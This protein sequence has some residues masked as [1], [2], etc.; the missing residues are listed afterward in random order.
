MMDSPGVHAKAQGASIV[1]VETL[2]KGGALIL[3]ASAFVSALAL[4]L[5]IF[6]LIIAKDAEREGRLAQYETT[7]LRGS[8]NAAGLSTEDP[9]TH[10]EQ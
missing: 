10:E 5:A 8:F 1:Q 7:L 2:G 6:A 3:W 9:L 4:G